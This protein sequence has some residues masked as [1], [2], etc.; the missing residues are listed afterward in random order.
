MLGSCEIQMPSSRRIFSLARDIWPSS[1]PYSSHFCLES[2]SF[3]YVFAEQIIQ[4]IYS[5]ALLQGIEGKSKGKPGVVFV[6]E[7]PDKDM[8]D[9]SPLP[10]PARAAERLV[11]QWHIEQT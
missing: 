9:P 6:S 2:A 10:A 4:L 3:A 7:D 5:C 1:Q 8:C 11:L